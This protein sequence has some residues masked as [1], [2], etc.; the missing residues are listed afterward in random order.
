MLHSLNHP[1][2]II[3]ITE[4]RIKSEGI[5]FPI[6]GLKSFHTP[7]EADAGGTSLYISESFKPSRRQ[8]LEKL[9]YVSKTLES[10]FGEFSQGSSVFVIGTI[11]K[12][13]FIKIR[14]FLHKLGTVMDKISS[15]GKFLVLLG[16]FNIDLLKFDNDSAIFRFLDCLG[17]YSL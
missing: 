4:T 8:D 6:E 1:F 5:D 10:T 13:P 7:T 11:Y 16:D 12:H 15:E 17:S 2:K 9:L 14:D 3:G